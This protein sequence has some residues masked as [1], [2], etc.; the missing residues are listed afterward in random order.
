MWLTGRVGNPV[1]KVSHS[2]TRAQ[3]RVM[4]ALG[5]GLA[6]DITF[7]ALRRLAMQTVSSNWRFVAPTRTWIKVYS[8][9]RAFAL[10]NLP[11]SLIIN[12]QSPPPFILKQHFLTKVVDTEVF[13]SHS[14]CSPCALAKQHGK[15]GRPFQC[16]D[17]MS[18]EDWTRRVNRIVDF[19]PQC[20]RIHYLVKASDRPDTNFAMFLLCKIM[21]FTV[22]INSF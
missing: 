16:A 21:Q 6:T 14:L 13:I 4:R 8:L 15:F 12:R 11:R 22:I 3:H 5:R 2:S 9:N 20:S 18:S 10:E 7:I 17:Q 1:H 19:S